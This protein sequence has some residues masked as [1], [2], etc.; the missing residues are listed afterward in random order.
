MRMHIAVIDIPMINSLMIDKPV[1]H[2]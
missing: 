2:A 1:N